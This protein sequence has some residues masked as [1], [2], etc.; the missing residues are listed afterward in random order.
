MV[1]STSAALAASHFASLKSDKVYLREG[2]TYQHRILF[3][4]RRKDYPLEVVSAYETWRRVRDIDGT[5]GW[6]SASMLSDA[7]SVLVVG[8]GAA[9]VSA[10]VFAGSPVIAR[11]EPGV[12][13]KLKA[14][15][16]SRCKI[17]A[18]GVAGWIDKNRLWGVDAGEVFN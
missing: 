12:V 18:A 11:A 17:A 7:R 5:V 13:A 16:P 14:C 9:A 15:Q 4:Y 1:L 3:I 8:K 10:S 6:I 2:P